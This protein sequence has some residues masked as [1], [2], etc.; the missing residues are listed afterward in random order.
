MIMNL[1]DGRFA[2]R[3]C[4][5]AHFQTMH[6]HQSPSVLSPAPYR[7]RRAQHSGVL[8]SRAC[9]DV[10]LVRRC[11]AATNGTA[12]SRDA[13]SPSGGVPERTRHL[14]RSASSPKP[15]APPA[16]KLGHQDAAGCHPSAGQRQPTAPAAPHQRQGQVAARQPCQSA[17]RLV[18]AGP[19]GLV[20]QAGMCQRCP[21]LPLPAHLR[22]GPTG[23]GAG[24]LPLTDTDGS[25][26]D[27]NRSA[28][29]KMRRQP[30]R[31]SQGYLA[32]PVELHMWPRPTWTWP[33]IWHQSWPWP[34]R[35][36]KAT[37]APDPC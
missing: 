16:S 36:A 13:R 2:Y 30:S 4:A 10:R 22:V 7:R 12:P 18:V 8:V 11:E 28:T 17:C 34:R 21:P 1:H 23:A 37:T 26:S 5:H 6:L 31:Q 32:W 29:R 9:R 3:V 20:G 27:R 35:R 33:G 15:P 25:I 24:E 14:T 19:R